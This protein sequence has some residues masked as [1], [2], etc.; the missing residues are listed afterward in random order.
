MGR[1]RPRLD[2]DLHDDPRRLDREHRPS[3]LTF[4]RL[5]DIVGRER[6][7]VAGLAVF[8]AGSALSGLA[9]S[10]L[11]LVAARA[12]Q[13]VG[14]ALILAPALALIVRRLEV[15][16]ATRFTRRFRSRSF[17]DMRLSHVT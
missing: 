1:L 6:V 14:A 8:T 17:I 7:W 11:L 4:G 12:I 15:S 10:L 5:A 13:G 16:T 3:L 9:P 2:R